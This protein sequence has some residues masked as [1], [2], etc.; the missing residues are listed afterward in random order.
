MQLLFQISII[1]FVYMVIVF[2]IAWA[3]KDNSIVDIFW[4]PGF[5]L[6]A[7]FSLLRAET[8]D[9]H[10]ILMNLAVLAWSLRLSIH[11]L[12]RNWGRD[13]D[14][15]Y[16]AWRDTWKHFVIR[17]FFSIFMLFQIRSF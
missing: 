1:I 12:L 11:I 8:I 5:I 15:R 7:G 10:K 2:M 14:F 17:S 9:L 13:E 3:K 6:I 16:K 4:G